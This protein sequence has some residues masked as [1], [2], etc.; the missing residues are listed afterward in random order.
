L[1]EFNKIILLL[2]EQKDSIIHRWL[3]KSVVQ[4]Y[5]LDHKISSEQF[6][7]KFA[8]P[9]LLYNL[10]VLRGNKI[11]GDCP[12]MNQFVNYMIKKHIKSQDIFIICTQLRSTILENLSTTHPDL[13]KN[14]DIMMKI[15]DFFDENL[16]GVLANFDAKV[17]EHNLQN[18]ENIDLKKYAKRVQI[19]LDTQK[20][21]YF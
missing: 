1:N 18:Q 15:L 14:S 16:S 17:L 9:I 7:K 21:Y 11:S 19:I 13:F 5:F 8:Q 20:K 4:R 2:I 6:A 10:D 12:I 3:S